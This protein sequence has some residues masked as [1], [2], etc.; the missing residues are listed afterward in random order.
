MPVLDGL[1]PVYPHWDRTA[2]PGR[3]GYLH[4]ASP[5]DQHEISSQPDSARACAIIGPFTD[6]AEERFQ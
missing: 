5:L 3:V 4:L 6:E 1:S 2:Y